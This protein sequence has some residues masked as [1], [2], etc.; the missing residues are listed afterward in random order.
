MTSTDPLDDE[1]NSAGSVWSSG[2]NRRLAPA[3]PW[4][5]LLPL[6]ALAESHREGIVD[7]GIGT[8]VDPTPEVV[9]AALQTAS[10]N[11]GY[12]LTAGT[13]ELRRA[14]ASW[15]AR[16]LDVNVEPAAVLPVIGTK[17]LV[18]ALPSQLGMGSGDLVVIP[19][20]AYP[21]YEVGAGIA[22]A[23]VRVAD[24]PDFDPGR[25]RTLVWLNSPANP[26]GRVLSAE[27]L[28]AWVDWARANDAVIASDECYAELWWDERPSS[29]LH[30][31]V[32]AGDH[33]RLLS[34]HS[35]S[36][37]SNLAGYRSGFVTGDPM[38]VKEL[39]DRR[40]QTGAMVPGPI[41][42]ASVAALDDDEHVAVQVAR[43]GARRSL[44]AA[45]IT[46]AG[47]R[48][49]DSSAGLYLWITRDEDCWATAEWFAERGILVG[50]GDFYGVAGARHVRLALSAT[51]ERVASAVARLAP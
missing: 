12:P 2:E 37:R 48:I 30:E 36:K 17:E 33:R 46:A 38:L 19:T 23:Q 18:A 31:D 25:G 45:V 10:D 47:F 39:L 4:D 11:P 50:P 27:Q 7:L 21:T 22:G 49:D 15:L 6:R 24:Q 28:R 16:R 1:V 5:R 34:V 26:S 51:D 20:L 29:L 13:P 9:Q 42:A 44:L 35:L 8:P 43:Y 41:Q 32:A 40:R 14:A 3:Y